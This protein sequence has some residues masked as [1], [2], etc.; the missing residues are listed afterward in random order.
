M[1]LPK[2]LTGRGRAGFT[3]IELLV[4]IAVI[5]V[6]AVAVLS[7]INPIE[8]VNKGRDTRT[9]SDAA[10]LLN[11]IDRYY[12]IQEIYPWNEASVNGGAETLPTI[13]VNIVDP[14]NIDT[15]GDWL[16]LLADTAEVKQQFVD[17]L[18]TDLEIT[19]DKAA[20]V[21]GVPATVYACFRPRSKQFTLEAEKKCA[22]GETPNQPVNCVAGSE[23]ICLP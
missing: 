15:P 2:L 14:A 23:L 8:Q 11:A 3:M 16:Q 12:A 6:L 9:R 4:V 21:G 7:S 10:Q 13:A 20:D 17:R 18:H 22:D 5:G 1:K 19:M